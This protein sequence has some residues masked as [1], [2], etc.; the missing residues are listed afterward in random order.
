MAAHSLS[1]G[2]QWFN[3]QAE[4]LEDTARASV[5][6]LLQRTLSDPEWARIRTRLLEFVHLLRTWECQKDQPGEV[7]QFRK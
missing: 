6:A 3:Q 2:R 5:D 1:S 4:P 7:I